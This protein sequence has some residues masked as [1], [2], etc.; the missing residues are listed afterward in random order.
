MYFKKVFS[1]QILIN[2]NI[3]KNIK[4]AQIFSKAEKLLK[5]MLRITI[6][7]N[8]LYFFV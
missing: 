1:C 4:Q 3:K 8:K 6:I 5:N 7:Y 2:S